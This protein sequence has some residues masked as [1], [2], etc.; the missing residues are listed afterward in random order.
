MRK[1][2]SVVIG[3][4]N[5]GLLYDFEENRPHPSTHSFAYDELDNYEFMCAIDS[6][7]SKMKYLKRLHNP[8]RYFRTLDEAYRSG[9]LD[10]IHVVSICTPPETHLDILEELL[11]KRIGKIIFCE[12]PIV[13]KREEI[14]DVRK[15]LAQYP[16]TKI[17]PNISRRWNKGLRRVSSE[18]ANQTYGELKKIEVRY[19]RG[20]YNTGSHLFDILSMWTGRHISRVIA[21]GK[22]DTS[23]LPEETYSFY[24]EQEDGVTGYAEAIDDSDYYVFDIDLFLSEGKIEMRCSGD[25]MSYFRTGPHHLFEGYRELELDSREGA[26]FED[27]CMR[28]AMINITGIMNDA[29]KPY[30]DIEDA[31]YPITVASAI[32]KSFITG[33]FEEIR[34]E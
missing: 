28:N 24:F 20:I 8:P 2:R 11:K 1:I 33:K 21:L 23:A 30:C 22:T 26:L 15:L 5:I 31:I 17:I 34:Y 12:K 9:I 7:E 18:I 6:D 3:L 14:A 13:E 19:T 16:D 25:E 10:K 4:G 32:E 29:Q 27:S